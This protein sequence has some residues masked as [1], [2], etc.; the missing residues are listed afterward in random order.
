MPQVKATCAHLYPESPSTCPLTSLLLFGLLPSLPLHCRCS[1]GLTPHP[2]C[3]LTP[4]TRPCAPLSP[5]DRKELLTLLCPLSQLLSHRLP[6]PAEFAFSQPLAPRASP[7]DLASRPLGSCQ[8]ARLPWG[9][10]PLGHFITPPPPVKAVALRLQLCILALDL[11]PPRPPTSTSASSLHTD[12]YRL[13]H[14]LLSPFAAIDHAAPSAWNTHC[15]ILRGQPPPTG[16][17]PCFAQPPCHLSLLCLTWT[18]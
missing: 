12:L 10:P 3:L 9:L 15:P 11:A 17:A 6:Q 16:S 8:L 4:G 7:T 5:G 1:H 18:H 14:D 2:P 13:E